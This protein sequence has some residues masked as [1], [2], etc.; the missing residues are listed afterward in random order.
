MSVSK[1]KHHSLTLPK[2]NR[3]FD[4][5]SDI[6]CLSIATGCVPKIIWISCIFD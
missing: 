5:V 1:L 2:A 6:F 3:F 4:K